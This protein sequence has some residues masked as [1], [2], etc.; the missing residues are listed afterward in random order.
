[1]PQLHQHS[2]C[3]G[4]LGTDKDLEMR[5]DPGRHGYRNCHNHLLIQY[6]ILVP[7]IK[8]G[9]HQRDPNSPQSVS[10]NV[11]LEISCRSQ[12]Q[13]IPWKAL[14]MIGVREESGE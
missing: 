5:V 2:R 7:A 13:G 14:S 10:S 1:M 11:S 12:L 4:I 3:L 6:H 8:A 9:G